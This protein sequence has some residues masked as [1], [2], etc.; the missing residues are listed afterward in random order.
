M[1]RKR[2]GNPI[3]L[4]QGHIKS[5]RSIHRRL[6]DSEKDTGILAVPAPSNRRLAKLSEDAMQRFIKQ[7]KQE[8]LTNR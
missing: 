2:L 1:R 6:L 8:Q 3:V 7:Y 4:K 5:S